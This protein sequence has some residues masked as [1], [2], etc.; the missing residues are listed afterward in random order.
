MTQTY[1]NRSFVYRKLDSQTVRS[2]KINGYKVAL[3]FAVSKAEIEYARNLSLCDLSALARTGFK[4]QGTLEW[5]ASENVTSPE[6][7]NMAIQDRDGCLIARLGLTEVLVL[8]DINVKSELPSLLNK[9]WIEH[10]AVAKKPHGLILPRQD[11]HACFA[12]SGKNA[13]EM[14]S[15]ICAV[16]LRPKTFTNHMIAQTSIAR[17]GS[18]IIRCDMGNNLNYFILVDSSLAEYLWDCL[19]DSMKEFDGNVIGY[20]AIRSYA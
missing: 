1:L 7:S 14:F 20:D 6:K 3:S 18:I 2:G 10:H 15:R 17:I 16:D 9:N 13:A 11:S 12:L 4:G 5:L 19:I 8:S